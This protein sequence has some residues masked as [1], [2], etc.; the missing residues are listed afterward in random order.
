M[1]LL[2]AVSALLAIGHVVLILGVNRAPEG[3]ETLRGFSMV[4]C[5]EH[6]EIRNVVCIWENHSESPAYLDIESEHLAA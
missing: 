4:W 2:A 6:P 3:C 1:L 5:N